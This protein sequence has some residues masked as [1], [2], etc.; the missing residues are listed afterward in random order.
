VNDADRKKPKYSVQLPLVYRKFYMDWWRL[1]IPNSECAHL[2]AE[3]SRDWGWM[4]IYFH[5]I[6]N[7]MC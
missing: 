2:H 3:D 7:M 1:Y 5:Y 6:E 4:E